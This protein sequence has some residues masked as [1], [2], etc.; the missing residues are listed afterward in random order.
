MTATTATRELTFTTVEE[1]TAWLA[2]EVSAC[3]FA[4]QIGGEIPED[5]H[6]DVVDTTLGNLIAEALASKGLLRDLQRGDTASI[7]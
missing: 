5:L 1:A 3:Y 6:H 4:M 7:S 2:A